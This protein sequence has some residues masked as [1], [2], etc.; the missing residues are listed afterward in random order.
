MKNLDRRAFVGAGLSLTSLALAATP[1]FAADPRVSFKV[2]DGA[3]DSHLHI[4]DPRFAYMP[5][6]V[7]KPIV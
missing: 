1:A 3:C 7:L 4:Y 6:A 2:P 5:N